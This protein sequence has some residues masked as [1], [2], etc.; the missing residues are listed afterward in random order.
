MAQIFE[1]HSTA[2]FFC[3]TGINGPAIVI[4]GEVICLMCAEEIAEVL[5]CDSDKL[6]PD[7]DKKDVL[8]KNPRRK[9]REEQ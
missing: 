8:S 3:R 4:G 6:C 2:C 7:S 5:N 9:S 1:M